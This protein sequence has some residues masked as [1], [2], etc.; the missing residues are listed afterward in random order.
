MAHKSGLFVITPSQVL[1]DQLILKE[2]QEDTQLKDLCRKV[3]LQWSRNTK[4]SFL[5]VVYQPK[6]KDHRKVLISA[7]IS[8]VLGSHNNLLLIINCSPYR[9]S[10]A[11]SVRFMSSLYC[12]SM[13][14]HLYK[15]LFLCC[16]CLLK[17]LNAFYS[18]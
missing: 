6:S 2:I 13:Y 16:I 9:C 10:S 8:P 18:S 15:N 7:K 5:N 14:F 1:S 11:S 17:I 4:Y 12:N 3:V